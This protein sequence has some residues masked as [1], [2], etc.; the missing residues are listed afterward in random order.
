L[1][2]YPWDTFSLNMT[3]YWPMEY[4]LY[5]GFSLK[6]S[7]ID[8]ILLKNEAPY[9]KSLPACTYHAQA[10]RVV[11]IQPGCPTY[12]WRT[13]SWSGSKTFM[14][15]QVSSFTGQISRLQLLQ[16]TL[17]AITWKIYLLVTF[18][19]TLPVS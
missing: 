12:C 17:Q 6:N 3:L 2:C 8:P 14:L 9:F 19:G 7:I 18:G 15:D 11:S 5:R 10:E 4:C 1:E 16:Y 13:L